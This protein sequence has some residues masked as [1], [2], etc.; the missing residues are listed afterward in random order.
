MAKVHRF[1]IGPIE[2]QG[3]TKTLAREAA[4]AGA[5]KALERC[6]YGPLFLPAPPACQ[7]E[8]IGAMVY[9][10]SG[11][12][13]YRLVL[14]GGVHG[15]WTTLDAGRT[16][17][18][19]HALGHLGDLALDGSEASLESVLSW[20][21]A[22]EEPTAYDV[23]RLHGKIRDDLRAKN[24]WLA[25]YTDARREGWNDSEAHRLASEY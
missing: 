12:W 8:V 3:A 15:C 17:A 21:D 5:A 9:P 2:G 22:I 23:I 20:L 7:G 4:L 10:W 13:V 1:K 14:S 19:V 16:E 18:I 25:R 11:G 6:N 24:A